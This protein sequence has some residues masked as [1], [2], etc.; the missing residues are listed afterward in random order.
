MGKIKKYKNIV[1]RFLSSE[2]GQRFFNAAYSLGAAV[3]ILGALFK[4][5]HIS[6]GDEMLCIGM[7]TE[8]V[9]FLLTAF[10]RSEPMTPKIAPTSAPAAAL[11]SM[12][13][14]VTAKTLT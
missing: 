8:V 5:L 7:L 2:G 12:V 11:S 6:G 9:M 3:V 4:I 13:A 1:E 10:D 14:V